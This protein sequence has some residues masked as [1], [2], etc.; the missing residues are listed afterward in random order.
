MV[1]IDESGAGTIKQDK[2]SLW[3]TAGVLSMLDVHGTLTT[4][5]QEMKNR[6]MRNPKEEL[7]GSTVPKH[8]ID[9]K[10]A[11]DVAKEVS[12]LM[13]KYGMIAWITGTD[14]NY[15]QKQSGCF[16]PSNAKKGL[17]AKDIARELLLERIS[18]Y[19]ELQSQD[20]YIYQLI[21][22]LSDVSELID[23]SAITSTYVDPHIK[24]ALSPQIIPKI[25]GALSHDWVELQI[26]DILSNFAL[27]YVAD[28]KFPGAD[29]DKSEAFKKHLC[30]R[31]AQSARGRVGVGWKLLGL[32]K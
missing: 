16:I 18:G 12:D 27:N 21:W 13:K 14:R 28:G 7:K 19:V 4:D 15:A 1:F 10:S 26:A 23:Y 20:D 5:F 11:D 31:L 29:K 6:L 25:L 3:I 30:P 32:E 2:N 17:Q 9:R 22:D 24:K 8:L